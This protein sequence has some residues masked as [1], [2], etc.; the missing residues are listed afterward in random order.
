MKPSGGDMDEQDYQSPP[1]VLPCG[2]PARCLYSRDGEESW[3]PICH[4]D[5]LRQRCEAAERNVEFYRTQY[6][7]A[8]GKLDPLAAQVEALQDQ[9]RLL[10]DAKNE[11]PADRQ[12]NHE[13][14]AQ[15]FCRL[16]AEHNER[17]LALRAANAQVEALTK[18]LRHCNCCGKD[19]D[20]SDPENAP[21]FVKCAVC[22]TKDCAKLT[23]AEQQ[24]FAAQQAVLTE[25]MARQSHS[26]AGGVSMN[27]KCYRHWR[28]CKNW[29]W[30][31]ELIW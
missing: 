31:H 16:A 19:A 23:A 5:A 21:I 9:I 18:R 6:V 12:S 29:Y 15:A 1:K 3:C 11:L 22:D 27:I 26:T 20:I 24:L 8:T 28:Y 14:L 10:T 30:I 7:E 25:G 4:L 17:K 2:H 13:M